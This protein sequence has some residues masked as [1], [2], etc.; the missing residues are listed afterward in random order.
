MGYARAKKALGECDRCGFTYKL[1]ELRYE[2]QDKTR[3]GLRVCKHCFDPDH[4]Q[5]R[6]GDVDTSDVQSLFDA[7]VDKGEKDSTSYFSFDPI[8]GGLDIF[9]S[10]TMGLKMTGDVGKLTVSTE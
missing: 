9:G 1:N 6:V 10:S 2:V 5:L 3:N 4:P 8:G 7:R